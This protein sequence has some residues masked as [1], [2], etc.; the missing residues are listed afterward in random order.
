MMVKT[1]FDDGFKPKTKTNLGLNRH[2]S[3]N[4]EV[5]TVTEVR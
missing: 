3:R 5:E 4:E 1:E 2:K